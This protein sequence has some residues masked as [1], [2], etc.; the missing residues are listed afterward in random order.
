MELRTVDAN[1]GNSV[2][3]VF[4][5]SPSR[6]EGIP[7]SRQKVNGLTAAGLT[8]CCFLVYI[9]STQA[10][11]PRLDLADV[12]GANGISIWGVDERDMSGDSVAHIGDFNGGRLS[13]SVNR[14][15]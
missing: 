4:I 7:M 2:L 9:A 5:S 3:E 1:I 14:S 8:A 13:R 12:D 11:G 6:S 15:E 10:F